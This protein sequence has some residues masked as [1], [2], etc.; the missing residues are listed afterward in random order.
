MHDLM[1]FIYM[2]RIN[3]FKIDAEYLPTTRIFKKITFEK[4]AFS[5]CQFKLE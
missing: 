5:I 2:R 4:K 1:T 3:C